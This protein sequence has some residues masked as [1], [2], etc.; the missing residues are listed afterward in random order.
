[1]VGQTLAGL[2]IESGAIRSADRLKRQRQNHCVSDKRFKIHVV[3][4]NLMLRSFLTRVREKFLKFDFDALRDIGEAPSADSRGGRRDI[5]GH[6][7]AFVH[8]LEAD[9]LLDLR[10]F[11]HRDEALA[12][13][14]WRDNAQRVLAHLAGTADEVAH[15]DGEC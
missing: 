10:A 6:E 15:A 8:G 13:L 5:R 11:F 4:V 12:Q 7:N 3:I 9:V 1:M 14:F 2:G